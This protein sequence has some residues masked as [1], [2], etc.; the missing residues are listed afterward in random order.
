M[1]E[2]LFEALPPPQ[3]LALAWS[4]AASRESFAVLLAFDARLGMA[5]RQANEPIM[6]QMRLAWW[7]DQMR[8]EA[9]RRERSDSLVAQMDRLAGMRRALFALI[10]G[11]EALLGEELG[12]AAIGEFAQGRGKAMAALAG[13]I[14]APDSA[15][16]AERAGARWAM[17][18]LAAGLSK[19]DE[20]ERVMAIARRD[21]LGRIGLSRPLR[22]LAVLDGLARRSLG[23]GGVPLLDGPASGLLAIR[24]GLLGR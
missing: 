9:D 21:G 15:E 23:R 14:G 17:A 1:D 8:L 11:W 3:R 5:I 20:R 10:D 19:A 24:L 2:A 12:E 6:A 4:P 18:D 13:L 7:R 22:T 16:S